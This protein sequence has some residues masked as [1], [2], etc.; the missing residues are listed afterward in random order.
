MEIIEKAFLS[1][2]L[3]FFTFNWL[4]TK[5]LDDQKCREFWKNRI[6]LRFYRKEQRAGQKSLFLKSG[7]VPVDLELYSASGGK[8][9]LYLEKRTWPP[10]MQLENTGKIFF[11][12]DVFVQ[13]PQNWEVLELKSLDIQLTSVLNFDCDPLVFDYAHFSIKKQPKDWKN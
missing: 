7:L 11:W 12:N 6:S 4:E 3:N 10:E 5:F 8:L 1:E 2:P 9:F 13:W